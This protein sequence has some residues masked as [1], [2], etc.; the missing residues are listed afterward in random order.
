MTGPPCLGPDKSLFAL[1]PAPRA[2]LTPP[3][4][5]SP[6]TLPAIVGG[7]PGEPHFTIREAEAGKVEW[8]GQGR[9]GPSGQGEGSEQTVSV[10]GVS[11]LILTLPAPPEP[12][13]SAP[14]QAV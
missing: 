3:H 2:T 6:V 13:T 8:R 9:L 12:C 14:G 5:P 7:V 4:V 10:W 11:G 1:V